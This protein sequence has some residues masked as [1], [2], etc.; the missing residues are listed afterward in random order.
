MAD[1]D[2]LSFRPARP[3][4]AEPIRQMVRTIWEGHDYL[5]VSI[6][7]RIAEG[8]VY[9]AEL[10]DRLVGVSRV[11]RLADDEWW[12]EG[13]RVDPQQWGLGLGRRLHEFTMAELHRLGHGM[14]RWSTA[15]SNRSVGFAAGSGFRKVLVLPFAGYPYSREK[16]LENRAAVTAGTDDL[17]LVD[18]DEPGVLDFLLAGCRE[19][20]AG[21]LSRGWVLPAATAQRLRE[22]LGGRPILVRRGPRGLRAAAPLYAGDPRP[23]HLYLSAVS[24][25]PAAFDAAFVQALGRLIRH[26][27]PGAD[28]WTPVPLPL[29]KTFLAAGLRGEEG[30]NWMYVY[31]LSLG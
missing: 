30:F 11:R 20:Y 3:A 14:A 23:D 21:L 10:R 6:D 17:A 27:H 8:G 28:L 26:L 22:A 25:E 29:E 12:L 16:S 18:I 24:G 31:E 2:E 19:H 4:D 1:F 13:L 9:V 5:V 15:D 7:R